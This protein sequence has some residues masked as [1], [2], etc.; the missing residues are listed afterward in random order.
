MARGL[1]FRITNRLLAHDAAIAAQHLRSVF[2]SPVDGAVVGVV[3][4]VL[5]AM[6]RNSLLTLEPF[7]QL[8]VAS[9]IA[10]LLA[11]YVYLAAQN[12]LS[13]F[14]SDSVL[15]HV[16]LAKAPAWQYITAIAVGTCLVTAIVLFVPRPS[17]IAAFVTSFCLSA[18]VAFLVAKAFALGRHRLAMAKQAQLSRIIASRHAGAGLTAAAVGGAVVVAAASAMLEPTVAMAVAVLAALALG[19]WYSPVSYARVDFERLIGFSPGATLWLALKSLLV[20]AVALTLGAA[21]GLQMLPVGATLG[22]FAFLIGYKG[23]EILIVRAFGGG[24]AQMLLAF[25][26]FAL[27]S[28]AVVIPALMAVVVPVAVLRL[29]RSGRMRTWQLG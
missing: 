24:Q 2:S 14:R 17:L 28:V 9:G 29:L 21:A 13:F 25:S 1:P 10:S 7:Y 15:A 16:A 23:L 26:L 19:L 3:M 4:I 18:I 27:L 5:I 20:L 6:A 8:A 11:P 22:A 12:R